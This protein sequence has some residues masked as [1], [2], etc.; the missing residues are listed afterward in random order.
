[1]PADGGW[2]VAEVAGRWRSPPS[3]PA[4][5]RAAI[6]AR[7]T[8]LGERSILALWNGDDISP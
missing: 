7:L 2:A 5:A 1:M 8:R 3:V 4:E 6:A